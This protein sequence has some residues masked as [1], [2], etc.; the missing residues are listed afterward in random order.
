MSFNCFDIDPNALPLRFDG[1]T[2]R[3]WPHFVPIVTA[4]GPVGL[5]PTAIAGPA[6]AASATTA[7]PATSSLRLGCRRR[8]CWFFRIT[9]PLLEAVSSLRGADCDTRERPLT[10]GREASS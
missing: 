9:S 5:M 7:A 1:P 2:G 4:A 8:P 6:I 3:D 10:R